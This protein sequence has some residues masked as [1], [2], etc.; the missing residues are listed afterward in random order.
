MFKLLVAGWFV[1]GAV[2]LAI[3]VSIYREAVKIERNSDW[4][5]E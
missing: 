5:C 3:V 1:T 2:I 4:F